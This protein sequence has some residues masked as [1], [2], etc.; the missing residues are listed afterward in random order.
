MINGKYT[1]ECQ[2]EECKTKRVVEHPIGAGWQVGMI[3]DFDPSE[4]LKGTCLLCHASG[5]K[6]ISSPQKVYTQKPKG[7]HR[8]P[9]K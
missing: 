8:V 3:V 9:T 4:P 6:V 2:N 1:L 5:M 7:F